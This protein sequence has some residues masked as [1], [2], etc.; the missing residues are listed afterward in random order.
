M[1]CRFQQRY[2]LLSGYIP[3]FTY[4]LNSEVQIQSETNFGG[5]ANGQS[6]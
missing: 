2:I 5:V 6:H 1:I 3:L 4:S